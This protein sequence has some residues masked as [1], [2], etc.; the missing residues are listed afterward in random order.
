MVR[1]ETRALRLAASRIRIFGGQLDG[2][3]DNMRIALLHPGNMG[4]TVGICAAEAGHQVSW[5]SAAARRRKGARSQ[6]DLGATSI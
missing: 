3:I 1:P 2:R 6:A 5:L 4:V